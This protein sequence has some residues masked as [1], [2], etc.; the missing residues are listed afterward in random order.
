[1]PLTQIPEIIARLP[2]G[3]RTPRMLEEMIRNL[4]QSTPMGGQHVLFELAEDD[5]RLYQDHQWQ[6]SVMGLQGEH[7]VRGIVDLILS[8]KLNEASAYGRLHDEIARLLRD[9][10]NSP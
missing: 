3:Q 9:N 2:D 8:G 10:L 6:K 5:P 7:S 1:M 4:G